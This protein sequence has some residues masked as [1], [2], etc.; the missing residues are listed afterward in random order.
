MNDSTVG[1]MM[2]VLGVVL[3]IL[4]VAVPGLF[5]WLFWIVV[6]ILIVYGLYQ[7]LFRK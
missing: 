3:A 2:F 4:A 7:W 6:I 1:A 5:Y